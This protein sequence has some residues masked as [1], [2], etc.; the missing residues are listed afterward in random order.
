MARTRW[1]LVLALALVLAMSGCTTGS[2]PADPDDP[3][4]GGTLYALVPAEELPSGGLDPQR[5]Y[6]VEGANL[7]TSFVLR[8]L[9]MLDPD[10]D[11]PA[12]GLLPDL[13]TD[14]GRPNNDASVWQFTLRDGATFEDGTVVECEHVAY[15]VSRSF[16]LDVI[17]D[18]PT[19]VVDMLD[20]PVLDDGSSAY[21]GPYTGDGQDFFDEAVTCEGSTITFRLKQPQGDFNQVAAF[22]ALGPVK[23]EADTGD[24]YSDAP[25]ASGPYRVESYDKGQR[26]VLVRNEAW[27]PA[28]DPQRPAYPDR[29]EFVLGLGPAA[30]DE[31]IITGSGDGRYAVNAGGGMQASNLERVFTD[32]SM[33]ERRL[34]V[35]DPFVM[36][37]A[38]NTARVP[39]LEHRQAI[40]AAMNRESIRTAAGGTFAGDEADGVVKPTLADD[41]APTEVWTGLLGRE[42]PADGDPDLVRELI[43]ASG[44]PMPELVFDYPSVDDGGDRAH[45]AFI[46]GLT[47]AGIPVRPN[48]IL[49]DLYYGTVLD[50][51]A[52]GHL[53]WGGWGPDWANASTVISPLFGAQGSFNLSRINQGGLVDEGFQASIEQG[54]ST[55]D[56]QEQSQIWQDLNRRAMELALVAPTLFT[57]TQTMWGSGLGGVEWSD[58]WGATPLLNV[59]VRDGAPATDT[60]Q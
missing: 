16:A 57:R 9:V 22:P 20:I 2:D 46:Q 42:V 52:Q 53:S 55:A 24:A 14:T 6:S 15:G 58:A 4:S 21:K 27:D 17:T 29:V 50:A 1:P 51:A 5:I 32:E 19:W 56:R 44:E 7:A 59:Y 60:P 31:Q 49:P 3:G 33:A 38:I 37:V 12:P 10:D 39:V 40:L 26:L 47:D 8:S 48:P 43:D 11:S 25:L 34:D 30:I 41:Y 13:A 35:L 28:T 18:G 54:L 45:L 36:Y 23:P